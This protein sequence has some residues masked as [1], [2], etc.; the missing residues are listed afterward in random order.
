MF[1]FTP[2]PTDE[3]QILIACGI[4]AYLITFPIIVLLTAV[5]AEV[6]YRSRPDEPGGARLPALAPGHP[7]GVAARVGPP[8][9]AEAT[10]AV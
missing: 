7:L 1:K 9:V 4:A 5:C 6:V 10:T 2:G 8:H 3:M